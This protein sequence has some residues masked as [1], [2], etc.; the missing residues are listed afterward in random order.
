MLQI[1]TR[2]SDVPNALGVVLWKSQVF[3]AIV[4]EVDAPLHFA[5]LLAQPI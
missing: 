2:S 5:T 3:C 1:E 4:A